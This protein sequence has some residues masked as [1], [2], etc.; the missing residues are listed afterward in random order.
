MTDLLVAEGVTKRFPW[1][2]ARQPWRSR[3]LTAVDHVSL[4][5]PEGTCLALVGESGS[6]KTTLARCLLRLV[7]PDSGT[8]TM[9]GEDFLALDPR[10]LRHRRR[11]VQMV[12]QD[13]GMAL[14]PRLRVAVQIAEPL[15]I[16]RM[17]PGSA[18]GERIVGLLER[19][20]L[21]ADVADRYPHQ[22]SGGQRQRVCIARALATEP[23]LLVLDEPVSALDVSV[24]ARI[25]DLLID[26]QRREGLTM[27]LISHD[28]AVVNQIADRVA[29]LYGGR[30]V[31]EGPRRTILSS[32]RHPYT[33][34]LM[35]AAEGHQAHVQEGEVANPLA[36]PSGCVFHPRCLVASEICQR[37]V[38]CRRQLDRH[39]EKDHTVACHHP[40]EVTAFVARDENQRNVDRLS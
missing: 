37:E 21:A 20:G 17:C 1:R 9:N 34:E 28:L 13:A 4:R 11:Q 10:A 26:L 22:L 30:L 2:E 18:T 24:Q 27:V 8:I 29:I 38:P 19:V 15:R 25:L 39:G 12:F 6:G 16:H 35:A 7:K 23:R 31:E 33:V 5:V 32:P 36:M 3:W 14:D 40:P